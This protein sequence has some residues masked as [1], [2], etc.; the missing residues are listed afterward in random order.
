MAKATK[1]KLVHEWAR[2][3]GVA[4]YPRREHPSEDFD[5]EELDP[6]GEIVPSPA[7]LDLEA[8]DSTASNRTE[9][10]YVTKHVP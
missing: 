1:V 6:D 4:T 2:H 9:G 10:P 7:N 3:E 5:F 8:P